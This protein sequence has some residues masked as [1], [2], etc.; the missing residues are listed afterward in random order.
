[1]YR[2][3]RCISLCLEAL[4]HASVASRKKLVVDLVP[5]C[6]FEKTTKK[7][8]SR[9][10]DAAWKL[11]KVCFQLLANSTG[12]IFEKPHDMACRFFREQMEFLS[13]EGLIAVIEFARSV[14]CLPDANS[15]EFKPET[16]HPCIIFMPE[17]SKTHM[18]GTMRLGSRRAYFH[19]KYGNKEFVD[20]R[21]R[22]RYEVNPEMVGFLKKSGLSIA[23]KD[24][25]GE[26]M[27]IVEVPSHPF[28]IDAQF[29]PEYKSRPGKN[30]E[31]NYKSLFSGLIAA[32][33]GEL[34]AVLNPVLINQDNNK[35]MA[36]GKGTRVD[37]KH[38][39][40]KGTNKK[41]QKHL[42]IRSIF[43]DLKIRTTVPENPNVKSI[44]V[45]GGSG[46]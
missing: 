4:L 2:P 17:G 29:H 20:E 16:N 41:S 22:H 14:L 12:L 3:L 34:D 43:C 6:D 19:V 15:S 27:E 21:H 38:V 37:P 39:F 32:S 45:E 28:F 8:N 5:S 30:F 10:Y 13:L 23:A 35:T 40:C 36:L 25:T 42:M 44:K 31:S 9:A 33:C 46:K 1:M 18:G 24:E 7:E 11:L 26:R